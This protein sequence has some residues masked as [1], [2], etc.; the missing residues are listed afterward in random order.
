[1]KARERYCAEIA[2]LKE[3]CKNTD[4][5]TLKIDYGRAIRRMK[6]ELA[7]YDYYHKEIAT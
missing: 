2:K 7:E 5:K 3:A 1:L 6:K 4:S